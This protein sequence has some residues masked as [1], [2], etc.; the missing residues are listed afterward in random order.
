MN[1]IIEYVLCY[2]FSFLLGM[3]VGILLSMWAMK[4]FNINE[5]DI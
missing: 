2:S 1:I 5:Y 4:A 3:F